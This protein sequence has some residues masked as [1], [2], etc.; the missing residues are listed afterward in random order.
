MR[1]IKKAL[2]TILPLAALTMAAHAQTQG[3]EKAPSPDE[4]RRLES[5]TWDLKTHTLKWTVQKGTEVKG[6]FVPSSTANYEIA[7]DAAT[8][9][10]VEEKRGIEPDEA[11]LLHRLLDT[12]ALYCA[13]SVI[14]WDHGEGTRVSTPSDAKPDPK[15]TLPL[16]VAE[17]AAHPGGGR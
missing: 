1:M 15:K 11:A 5:V 4:V 7:P 10:V 12:I 6:E 3:M 8:M 16:G 9:K 2:L 14:W 17:A 13:Q